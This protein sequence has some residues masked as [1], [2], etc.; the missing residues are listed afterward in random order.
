MALDTLPRKLTAILLALAAS[1]PLSVSLWSQYRT[2]FYSRQGTA[3]S[4]QQAIALQPGNAELHNRLGRVLLYSPAGAAL[5]AKGELERAAA[6]DPRTAT[7]TIDVALYLELAD[8]FEGAARAIER[9]RRVEPRT[10]FILWHETNFWLRREQNG[11]AMGLARELLRMAPEYTAR[12][13][14]LLLRV[15]PGSTLLD[16]V[17]PKDVN[18]YG[19]VLEIFRREDRIESAAK[20]WERALELGQPLPEGHVRMFVDWVLARGQSELALRAWSDAA[21]HGWIPVDPETLSEPLYNADFHYPLLNFG[22]DWR[23]EAN[24]DA[25]VWVESGGPRG[26]QQSL[27]VQFSQDARG[28]YAGVYHYAAV[29]PA[30]HYE[31]RASM[32]TDKLISNSGAWLQVQEMAPGRGV[33][34]STEPLMGTNPWKEVLLQMETGPETKLVRLA[35]VRPAPT[36][37]EP[38]SS[39]LVCVSPLEWKPLGPGRQAGPTGAQP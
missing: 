4:L 2:D 33:T 39:G 6:L 12:A 14:P 18:A 19:N 5:R 32:R 7:Y 34:P 37:K 30:H 24:A 3:E 25:S 27:C 9:A 29:Q 1:V 17:V 20:F 28:D 31:L 26:G 23:V 22:F 13:V 10:P 8:D 38:P 21:R 36:L 35:L 16:D 11:R 15:A